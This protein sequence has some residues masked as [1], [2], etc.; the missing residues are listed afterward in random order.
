MARMEFLDE[1]FLNT[2]TQIQVDS[3]TSTISYLFDRNRS[4]GFTSVGYDGATS[5]VLSIEFDSPTAI[6][7][8]LM[9]GHNLKDFRV[10]YDSTTANSLDVVSSNSSSSYYLSFSTTTVSSI[11]IQMDSAFPSGEK[12]V[13][14]LIIT[15]RLVQF[16]RNPTVSKWKPMVYRKQVV[17]E[18]PDGGAATFN[19]KDKYRAQLSWKFITESFYDD[20]TTVYNAGEP[21]YFI[22]FP[23]ATAW[24]G[25][26]HEVMWIG[27]FDFK[28]S[29]NDKDQ[30]YEGKIT[31]RETPGG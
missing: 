13:G 27:N 23:T 4:L 15:E 12:N 9:Q 28:H 2:T 20:L 29:T 25:V 19:V 17:H 7:H 14:E 16:E 8:V 18:M 30:G 22:P 1:N 26:G 31:L 3:G 11:Q 24:D 6:S 10:F 21:F 5:T